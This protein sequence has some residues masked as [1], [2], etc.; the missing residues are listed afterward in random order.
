MRESVFELSAESAGGFARGTW[1]NVEDLLSTF[2][3]VLRGVEESAH[4]DGG[5]NDGVVVGEGVGDSVE[6]LDWNTRIESV[7]DNNVADWTAGSLK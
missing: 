2:S 3:Q 7:S 5:R 1:S 4:R 6:S